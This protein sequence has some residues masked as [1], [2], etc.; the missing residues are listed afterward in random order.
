[1]EDAPALARSLSGYAQHAIRS[2]ARGNSGRHRPRSHPTSALYRSAPDAPPPPTHTHHTHT[3]SPLVDRPPPPFKNQ[4]P[5]YCMLMGMVGGI[6]VGE[7]VDG[8]SLLQA[9][10][11]RLSP[12][13]VP[14][15][16]RDLVEVMEA[17]PSIRVLRSSTSRT[18][19]FRRVFAGKGEA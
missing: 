6:R 12:G 18:V 1:M 8:F 4:D 5:D 9:F 10:N 2:G 11:R 13:S 15:R 16:L 7:A 17:H 19:S 3:P 14:W